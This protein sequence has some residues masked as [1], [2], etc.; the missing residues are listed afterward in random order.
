MMFKSLFILT[1]TILLVV[2]A[3]VQCQPQ[4]YRQVKICCEKPP[5]V[6]ISHFPNYYIILYNVSTECF[7][8]PVPAFNK[9]GKITLLYKSPLKNTYKGIWLNV[10][11]STE[12]LKIFTLK[13]ENVEKLYTV[14]REKT[15]IHNQTYLLILLAS[16]LAE[17]YPESIQPHP[18]SFTTSAETTRTA[19]A[20]FSAG[21][22]RPIKLLLEVLPYILFSLVIS[23]LVYAFARKAVQYNEEQAKAN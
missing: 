3:T 16:G 8:V 20:D 17:A 4:T 21:R 23:V 10:T 13:Q 5:D 15:I 2:L 9:S 7:Y 22:A 18:T 14:K 6:V 12:T 19:E 11:P 1:S